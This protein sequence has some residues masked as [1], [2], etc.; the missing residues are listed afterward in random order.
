MSNIDTD[1]ND[2]DESLEL[3]VRSQESETIS[4]DSKRYAPVLKQNR[5]TAE[6]AASGVT[7]VLYR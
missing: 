1:L 2:V 4:I 5:Q 7:K 6:Y 3:N